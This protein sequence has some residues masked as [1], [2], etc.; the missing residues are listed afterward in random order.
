MKNKNCVE[1]CPKLNYHSHNQQNH[2]ITIG[3]H[4]NNYNNSLILKC[5]NKIVIPAEAISTSETQF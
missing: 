4:K 2:P 1:F 5:N 3:N